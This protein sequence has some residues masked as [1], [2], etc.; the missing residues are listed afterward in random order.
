M[1]TACRLYLLLEE[2]EQKK[3]KYRIRNMF[4]AREKEGEF[5]TMWVSE[6]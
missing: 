2:E 1:I 6:K 5:K 3:R 4:Q